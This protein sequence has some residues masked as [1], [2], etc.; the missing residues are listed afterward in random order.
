MTTQEALFEYLHEKKIT[1]SRAGP[2][3]LYAGDWFYTTIRGV[4][5]PIFPLLG[6]RRGLPAHDT[7]H[8]LNEYQTDWAGE[9]ETAAW[10]LASGGCGRYL[11]YW[12]DRLFFLAAAIPSAPVRTLRAWQRGRGQR[13]LYRLDPAKLLQMELA[14]VRRYVSSETSDPCEPHR[15]DET[16]C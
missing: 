4:Q 15:P 7:H 11:I 6:F 10:E 9:C 1:D 12:V 5:V 13:N 2:G 8:M 14:D 3:N 16:G